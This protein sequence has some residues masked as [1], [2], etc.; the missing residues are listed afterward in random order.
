MKKKIFSGLATV[1][2]LSNIAMP[3]YSV[4]AEESVPSDVAVDVT[5]DASVE[6]RTDIVGSD[7]VVSIPAGIGSPSGV[8][9]PTVEMPVSG[10]VAL[11]DFTVRASEVNLPD[12][13]AV[14]VNVQA[15]SDYQIDGKNVM[16]TQDGEAIDYVFERD[17]SATYGFDDGFDEGDAFGN[18]TVAQFRN[19]E[20]ALHITEAP[21][22]I[23]SGQADLVAGDFDSVLQF[24]T[25]IVDTAEAPVEEEYVPVVK[26]T[27]YT[28]DKFTFSEDGT[29]LTGFTSNALPYMTSQYTHE[30]QQ[31]IFPYLP[32]VTHIAPSAFY[33]E[34]L[35]QSIDLT[36]LPNL[37]VIGKNAF[38]AST[39]V[40]SLEFGYLPKLKV[41][42]HAAFSRMDKL[43]GDF[44]LG[45]SM[46]NIEVI[47]NQAFQLGYMNSFYTGFD[48]VDFTGA[49]KLETIG[50]AAFQYNNL[51]E[52]SL[53]GLNNLTRIGPSAFSNNSIAA[54][55]DLGDAPKLENVGQNAFRNNRSPYAPSVTDSL[56]RQWGSVKTSFRAPLE[57][58]RFD[59]TTLTA[60]NGT[61]P[62]LFI[63]PEN[64]ATSPL[65]PDDFRYGNDEKTV[66]F[67]LDLS[68][69]A[70]M[71][72]NPE[73]SENLV[74]PDM[75]DVTQMSATEFRYRTYGAMDLS[76]LS[77]LE[78][79]TYM[80]AYSSGT[81]SLDISVLPN[82][83]EINGG[84]FMNM[85]ELT[86]I[87]DLDGR[88][89][90]TAAD[91]SGTT[92]T[93]AQI[94]AD[95]AHPKLFAVE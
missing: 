81:E 41:I 63:E 27:Y 19:A 44:N 52:L 94:V 15:R 95:R 31:L 12:H 40:T 86:E 23:V 73:L 51:S 1:M 17:E 69:Q 47:E 30:N 54:A 36:G 20:H 60:S 48:S 56:N 11:A 22:S 29:T 2:T 33:N 42:G 72:M 93:M 77:G 38:D 66:I 16:L 59:L 35:F 34:L 5:I 39:N 25:G 78:T 57:Y 61:S 68:G 80:L 70:K 84:A 46:P 43:T 37:E 6:A 85:T 90:N 79:L 13:Q 50:T 14:Q 26:D 8:D 4:L 3:T 58:S 64:V 71:T 45:E 74:F 92:W 89:W 88:T 67:G 83:K 53:K 75:P 7:Y 9:T 24:T 21:V 65:T 55:I 49:D 18:W 32:N 87:I 28:E 76:G 62:N 91:G 82:L 10:N